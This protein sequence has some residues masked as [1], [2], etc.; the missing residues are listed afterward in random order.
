MSLLN[1]ELVARRYLATEDGEAW[2]ELLKSNFV[3]NESTI[4]IVEDDGTESEVPILEIPWIGLAN[5]VVRANTMY[6]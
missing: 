1:V 4:I 2:M 5:T 6:M 3:S